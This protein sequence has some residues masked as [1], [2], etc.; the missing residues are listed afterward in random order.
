MMEALEHDL[1]GVW[2]EKHGPLP[3]VIRIAARAALLVVGKY[4]ALSDDCEVYRIAIGMSSTYVKDVT[5]AFSQ[6]CVQIKS[7]SGLR[8]IQIGA[9]EILKKYDAL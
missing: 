1:E 4:Y 3:P 9:L 8:S 6:L 7:S 5:D 2:L